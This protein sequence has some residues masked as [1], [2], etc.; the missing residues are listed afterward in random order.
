MANVTARELWCMITHGCT[1]AAGSATTNTAKA[2]RN[3]PISASTRAIMLMAD[4]REWDDTA[5]PMEN[6]IKGNGLMA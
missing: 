3:F 5:G 6:S 4:L 1:K 2:M